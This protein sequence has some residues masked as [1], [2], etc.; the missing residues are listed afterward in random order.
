MWVADKSSCIVCTCYVTVTIFIKL[1]TSYTVYSY[2]VKMCIVVV[3]P[4]E[5]FSDQNFG[6][7]ITP[8]ELRTTTTYFNSVH[9]GRGSI[10]LLAYLIDMG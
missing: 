6:L 10:M 5:L 2:T 8:L 7:K 3:T 1:Y 4:M 9:S